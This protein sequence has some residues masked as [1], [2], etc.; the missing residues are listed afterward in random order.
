MSLCHGNGRH[1]WI[2]GISASHNGAACL[3]RGSE[4][5][6]A[7][8]EERLSGRKRDRILASRPSLAVDYCLQYAG[9]GL[10][11]LECAVVCIQGERSS[12]YQ[13][14][15]ANAQLS[16]LA[17]QGRIRHLPHHLGHAYSALALSGAQEAAILVV[18]GMGSPLSDLS[19]PERGAVL[20]GQS[21]GWEHISLYAAASG[22]ITPIEKHLVSKGLWI[23]K[24]PPGMPLFGSLGG[25]YSAA[26]HQ[27]FGDLMEAGKVMGLSP[28]GRQEY[29]TEQFFDLCNGQFAFRPDVPECFPAGE[30]WPLQPARQAHLAR[31]VQEALEEA[32]LYLV[33][34][35]RSLAPAATLCYSGGVA[36]NVLI[37]ERIRQT[38]QFDRLFIPAA[39]EDSGAALGAAF[40]GL[41]QIEPFRPNPPAKIDSMGKTYCAA[42]IDHALER[43]PWIVVPELGHSACEEAA[44]RLSEGQI[45]GWFQGGAELGPR[46]LGHRSILADARPEQVK[47]V[48]NDNIKM[49]EPFQPFAPAVLAHKAAEW[50]VLDGERSSPFMLHA[51]QFRQ[52]RGSA[53]PAV[54]HVDGTGRAQTVDADN[55]AFYRLLTA[56]HARTGIPI[57][58]NTSFNARG[59][60]IVETPEDALWCMLFTGLHFCVLHD[61]IVENNAGCVEGLYPRYVAGGNAEYAFPRGWA[62][63]LETLDGKADCAAV[64]ERIREAAETAVPA[65]EVLLALHRLR[66]LGVIRLAP[67]PHQ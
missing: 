24:R 54:V 58:L 42:E 25:M 60:P 62:P 1:P 61:R 64:V 44:E 16:T 46:A 27:I 37:N 40:F 53:A 51:W 39:T 9:I 28:Y 66:R 31:S 12:D 5:V 63:V 47:K 59:E 67:T 35:L 56:F 57:L 48:L 2:L 18:D 15:G 41:W 23:Q 30:R 45:C 52:D 3:L 32:I 65:R 26:A 43:F 50:F 7:I 36:L 11:D 38:R 21:E 10:G 29:R 14:I 55:S 33:S 22:A 20:G 49:R 19:E 13:D 34:R 8:Q 6:V 4:I 17:A